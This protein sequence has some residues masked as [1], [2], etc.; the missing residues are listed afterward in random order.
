MKLLII[1]PNSI[2]N[3]TL[4]TVDSDISIHIYYLGLRS[5]TIIHNVHYISIN[6]WV[7]IEH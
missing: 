6:I 7:S 4:F 3:D 1:D 2:S 5:M